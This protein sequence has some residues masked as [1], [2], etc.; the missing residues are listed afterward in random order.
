[1]DLGTGRISSPAHADSM[2]ETSTAHTKRFVIAILP[3]FPKL[4]RLG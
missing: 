3:T 4:E 1:M 2:L